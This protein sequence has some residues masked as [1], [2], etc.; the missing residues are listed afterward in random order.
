MLIHSASQLLTLA[1]G[2]Q[3]GHELGRLG[4]IEDGAVLVRGGLIEAVGPSAVLRAAYPNEDLW[5]AGGRV[6]MPGFVDP[7]T[8]L[9]WAGEPSLAGLFGA[10][11]HATPTNQTGSPSSRNPALIHPATGEPSPL[12]PG[13]AR[14]RAAG[15][16]APLVEA[17]A[18]PILS[19]PARRRDPRLVVYDRCDRHGAFPGQRAIVWQRY[20]RWWFERAHLVV[21]TCP[22]LLP[23]P[24]DTSARCLLL[25][26]AARPRRNG[27]A[28]GAPRPA[29][30]PWRLLSAGAHYEWTDLPWLERL[31]GLPQVELHLAGPGRG[32]L[33]ARL[34]RAPAVRDHGILPPAALDDLMATCH[35]GLISFLD[36]PLTRAVDPLKAYEYK[37]HDLYVWATGPAGLREHPCVDLVSAPGADPAADW[38]TV[39]A[40]LARPATAPDSAPAPAPAGSP[41]AGERGRRR[42]VPSW[43]DRLDRLVQEL[44]VLG[45]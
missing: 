42:R 8:H 41:Q 32:P 12:G 14:R 18:A 28:S 40:H 20:E 4:L 19:A 31:A 37:M 35:L 30:P 45:C 38:A 7:H 13:A 3:R 10:P 16:D 24:A 29:P 5:D 43:D 17:E 34:R 33:F 1:G 2:P 11:P 15:G 27:R 25:P 39:R 21:A 22:A 26:N 6:V 23:T 44:E 36:L 9:V